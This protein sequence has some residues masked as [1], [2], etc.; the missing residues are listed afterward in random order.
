LTVKPKF[1][2]DVDGFR[3]LQVGREPWKLAKELVSNSF[4]ERV[5]AVTVSLSLPT[6]TRKYASLIVE[7]DGPGFGDLKDAYTL[8]APTPK[9]KKPTVRGRFNL[10]EKEILSVAKYGAIYTTTGAIEFDESTRTHLDFDARRETGTLVVLH[11]EWSEEECF[12]VIH[13][14]RMLIPP[15]NITYIVNSRAV[16]QP[17]LLY[18]VKANLETVLERKGA[19]RPTWRNTEIKVFEPRQGEV[20]HLMELGIPVEKLTSVEMPWHLDVQQKVPLSVNRDTV[21]PS[22]IQDVLAEV[23]NSVVG[24]LS[25]EQVS[26]TWVKL[27][28]ADSRV[29]DDTVASVMQTR[30]PNAVIANPFDKL[31]VERAREAGHTVIFGRTLTEAERKR[32]KG[33]VPTTT[34]LYGLEPGKPKRVQQTYSMARVVMF[35]ERVAPLLIGKNVNVNFVELESSY[36]RAYCGWDGAITFVVN[37]LPEHFFDEMTAELVELIIHELAHVKPNDGEPHGLIWKDEV[38]RLFGLTVMLALRKPELF[39][40]Y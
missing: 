25:Q 12:E 23:L 22:Y 30:F 1:E 17:K 11:L 9:Q 36:A 32:I 40:L 13:K 20:P 24:D 34:E 39:N 29:T 7:D 31:S 35:I 18:T 14:L 10:G 21:K 4:D 15:E 38:Q 37:Q 27:A 16:E 8:Y 2:V 6:S 26:T 33:I 28:L 19:V 5:T 3:K